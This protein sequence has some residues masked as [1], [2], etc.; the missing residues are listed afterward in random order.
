VTANARPNRCG[1]DAERLR[2]RAQFLRELEEARRLRA[3][4]APRRTRRARL[5]AALRMSTFRAPLL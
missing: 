4:V 5:R 3:R 1:L 2:R